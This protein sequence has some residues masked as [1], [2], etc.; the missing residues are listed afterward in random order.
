MYTISDIRLA[1]HREHLFSFL[2]IFENIWETHRK[3]REF[4]NSKAE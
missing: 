1:F 2:E 4:E 3:V